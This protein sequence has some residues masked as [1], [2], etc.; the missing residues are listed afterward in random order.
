MRIEKLLEQLKEAREKIGFNG[1]V[2]FYWVSSEEE[3]QEG[4]QPFKIDSCLTPENKNIIYIL[5]TP[6]NG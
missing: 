5:G 3:G 6:K 2:I 4:I 1:E